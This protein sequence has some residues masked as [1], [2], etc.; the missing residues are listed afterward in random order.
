MA[1]TAAPTAT[2]V[3]FVS[4]AP[5]FAAVPVL[6]RGHQQWCCVDIDVASGDAAVQ[7]ESGRTAS[8][9]AAAVHHSGSVEWGPVAN[10]R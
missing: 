2:V 8:A 6:P 9:N 10:T 4:N 7:R 5:F 1:A 3:V